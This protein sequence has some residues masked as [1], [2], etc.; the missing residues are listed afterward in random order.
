MFEKSRVTRNGGGIIFYIKTS[1]NPVQLSKPLI[2]NVDAL[3][4]LLKNKYGKKLALS[5]V[6]RPPAQSVQTDSDLYEQI[7]EI[8]DAHDAIILGDFNLPLKKW[9]EPLT[10]YHGHDLYNNLKKAY[11]LSL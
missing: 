1:L 2:A 3:F 7:S 9:G 5:L 10:V 4:I 11:L 8:S 6:Y